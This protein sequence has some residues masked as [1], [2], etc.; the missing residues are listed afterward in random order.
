MGSSTTFV[1]RIDSTLNK[2]RAG[3]SVTLVHIHQ[4][5]RRDTPE[6]RNTNNNDTVKVRF[7]LDN[8][9]LIPL[10]IAQYVMI[11][12]D[13]S[14]L[15]CKWLWTCLKTDYETNSSHNRNFQFCVPWQTTSCVRCTPSD[16]YS[17]FKSPL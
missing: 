5:S 15:S 11:L 13:Q 8:S 2:V 10:Y 7:N 9:D 12:I 14:V 4:T 17:I 3:S 1:T 6:N 16:L